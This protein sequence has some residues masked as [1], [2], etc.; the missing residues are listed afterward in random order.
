MPVSKRR[1]LPHPLPPIRH[2]M[3]R[4]WYL[5]EDHNSQA[6]KDYIASGPPRCEGTMPC[7]CDLDRHHIIKVDEP[8]A[9]SR[10][11]KYN[12]YNDLTENIGSTPLKGTSK[13]SDYY[14]DRLIPDTPVKDGEI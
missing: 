7:G 9:T 12:F 4:R 3:I 13:L 11:I 8:V 14:R 6:Y 1:S 2:G 5:C 10:K